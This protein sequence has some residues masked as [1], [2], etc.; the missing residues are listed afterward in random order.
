VGIAGTFLVASESVPAAAENA[1]Q[2][3]WFILTY[4]P[5]SAS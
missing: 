3:L 1:Q 4:T 5:S 2:V